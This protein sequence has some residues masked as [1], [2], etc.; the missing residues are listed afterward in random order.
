MAEIHCEQHGTFIYKSLECP[1][2]K[3]EQHTEALA[4]AQQA[5]DA[6]IEQVLA[7]RKEEHELLLSS[8][9]D[10][11]SRLERYL[12]PTP[13]VLAELKNKHYKNDMDRYADPYYIEIRKLESSINSI[14]KQLASLSTRHANKDHNE[15]REIALTH[16][17]HQHIRVLLEEQHRLATEEE[18]EKAARI[19][20][21]HDLE[22]LHDFFGIRHIIGQCG[23]RYSNL[24]LLGSADIGDKRYAR[25]LS[26][27]THERLVTCVPWI[28]MFAD[29][30]GKAISV[31]W[32][33]PKQFYQVSNSDGRIPAKK[34]KDVPA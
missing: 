15:I 6:S 1:G 26:E 28:D 17:P 13:D 33:E 25:L 5:L 21:K 22:K 4:A 8:L 16:I 2:C 27:N 14:E 31:L 23:K 32:V 3:Y 18:V 29:Q 9:A 30:I 24:K 10:L 19:Q 7:A 11:R 20:Q 34:P 12:H